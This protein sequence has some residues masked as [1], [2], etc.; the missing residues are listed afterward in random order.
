MKRFWMGFAVLL[1]AMSV[2]FAQA[3][4][5]VDLKDREFT[6]EEIVRALVGRR[7]SAPEVL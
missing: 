2:A 4:A 1:C 6:A 5:P 3:Q 7:E